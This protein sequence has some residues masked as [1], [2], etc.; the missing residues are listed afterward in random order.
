MSETTG[1]HAI[2]TPIQ[3]YRMGSV[4]KTLPSLKT[5]YSELEVISWVEEKISYFFGQS[6]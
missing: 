2:S 5:R 3:G 4:G 1:P 6:R